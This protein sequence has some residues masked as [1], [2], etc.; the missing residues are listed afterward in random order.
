MFLPKCKCPPFAETLPISTTSAKNE[1]PTFQSFPETRKNTRKEFLHFS[2]SR[3]TMGR[4]RESPR[5]PPNS[6]SIAMSLGPLKKKAAKHWMNSSASHAPSA[7]FARSWW[8]ALMYPRWTLFALVTA[9]RPKQLS[10]SSWEGVSEKLRGKRD[11][12]SAGGFTIIYNYL[13]SDV[14]GNF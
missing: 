5:V 6:I 9:E 7:A 10:Y 12:T 8:R 1:I 2:I 13:L 14:F 3:F 11:V 4:S